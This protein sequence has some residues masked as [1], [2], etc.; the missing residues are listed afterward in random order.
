MSAPEPELASQLQG[1]ADRGVTK[2]EQ[3][4]ALGVTAIAQTIL[5]FDQEQTK[6]SVGTGVLVTELRNGGRRQTAR[7][8]SDLLD[9]EAEYGQKIVDWLEAKMPD[10][11]R[12]AYGPH[13]AAVAAVVRLHWRKGKGSLTVGSSGAEIRAAVQRFDERFGLDGDDGHLTVAA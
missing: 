2:P 4:A 13:P 1:L 6:R 11:C 9:S 7:R 12:P 8:A 5:W 10:V 3:F